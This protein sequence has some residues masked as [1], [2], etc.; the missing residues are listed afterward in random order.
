MEPS[1]PESKETR[2]PGGTP[3]PQRQPPA[4][5]VGM[6]ALIGIGAAIGLIFGLMLDNL[7][8]GLII[9][10]AIGTVAGAVVE[11]NRRQ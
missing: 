5:F 11:A 8:W 3:E 2:P 1:P 9:G 6:G 10:A 7:V 4:A